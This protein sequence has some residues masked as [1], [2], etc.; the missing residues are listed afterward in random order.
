M[1]IKIAGL[2]FLL[3]IV[4][5]PLF[6]H[7]DSL[8]F[9][10]WDESRLASNAYEMHKNGNLIVTYY[11]GEPEMWSTKPPLMIWLQVF[12]IRIIGFNEMAV[13]L[14]A[15]IAG[16][17]TCVVLLIFSRQYFKNLLIGAFA[18]VVLVTTNGY[19]D[20]HAIRTGDYDGLLALFTTA[21]TLAAFMY[22][23]NT[24]KKWVIVFFAGITMAV[25][26]KSIQPLLFLPGVLIYLLLRKKWNL[27]LSRSFLIGGC[28][29]LLIITAYYVAREQMNPGYLLAVW[30]NELGGRYF[31]ALEENDEG[32]LY[33]ISR[34]GYLYPYW[35][36]FL[37][38]GIISG[39]LSRDEKIRKITMF[40]FILTLTYFIFITISKTKL[41][42]YSVPLF[43]LMSLHVSILL[44]QVYNYLKKIKPLSSYSIVPLLIVC[45][46]FIYPY[47]EIV[48]KVYN[49]QEYNWDKMYPVSE[50]LQESFHGRAS[51][52]NN[53][54]AYTDYDQHLKVYTHALK[55]MGQQINFKH[56]D[57]LLKGDTVIAS[58]TAVY[59]TIESNYRY[60]LLKDEEGVRIYLIK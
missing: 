49:P 13:R 22:A 21:F 11:E 1:F 20:T 2:L 12:F 10:L 24:D 47:Q 36:W 15:A 34:T 44:Y 43:P 33:Y 35:I 32:P 52:N 60:N 42:W 19:V 25:L 54:I 18:C 55:D 37:P 40:T 48:R 30:N 50:L 57:S 26:T 53:V 39:F 46:V 27:L 38:I 9:R 23:E 4:S 31:N 45:L 8:P 29:A 17:L 56:P 16:L 6:L 5:V 3:L 51:L 41:Y 28:T 7:L 14:P 58:E 59:N